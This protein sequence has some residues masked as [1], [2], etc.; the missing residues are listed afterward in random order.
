MSKEYK[1]E[2]VPLIINVPDNTAM[3]TLTAKVM[4]DKGEMMT[5]ESIMTLKEVIEARIKGEEWEDENATWV[6]TD[7]AREFLDNGGTVDELLSRK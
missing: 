7:S 1:C 4:D 2:F 3:L 5:V 6:F